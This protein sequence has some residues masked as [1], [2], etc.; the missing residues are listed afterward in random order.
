MQV[1]ASTATAAE[2]NLRPSKA[3]ILVLSGYGLSV[4][5][6]RGHLVVSDGI[7][8]DRHKGCLH[9]ATSKLKRLVVLGHTG[10]VTFDALRWLH[11][12]GAAFVQVDKDGAIICV[13]APIGRGMPQLRRAQA[14][15]PWTGVGNAITV[16]LLGLKIRGQAAVARPLDASAAAEIERSGQQL[17]PSLSIEQLRMI[18][19]RAA[20]LYWQALAPVP[21]RFAR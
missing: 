17:A 2:T 13:S 10:F 3:G 7:A 9:R 5:V 19:A 16:E 18:E 4:S 11:D 6:E 1:Q 12:V 15:A 20:G 21:V 14:L 8:G